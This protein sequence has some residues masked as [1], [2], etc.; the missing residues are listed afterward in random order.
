LLKRL[1]VPCA[2]EGDQSYPKCDFPLGPYGENSKVSLSLTLDD[3]SLAERAATTQTVAGFGY[4]MSSRGLLGLILTLLICVRS[5]ALMAE[6]KEEAHQNRALNP[7]PWKEGYIPTPPAQ[8]SYRQNAT[9]MEAIA[10]ASPSTA[11]Q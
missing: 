6:W 5:S 4:A 8:A 11:A 10:S 3:S 1:A 7:G 2:I 9:D